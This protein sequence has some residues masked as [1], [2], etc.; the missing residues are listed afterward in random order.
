MRLHTLK[1]RSLGCYQCAHVWKWYDPPN[2]PKQCPKCLS[3]RWDWHQGN[4]KDE[5]IALFGH[6]FVLIHK[7]AMGKRTRIRYTLELTPPQEEDWIQMYDLHYK[8]LMCGEVWIGLMDEEDDMKGN[9]I[10]KQRDLIDCLS[11][12]ASE[13]EQYSEQ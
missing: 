1:T 13:T 2:K 6:K 12:G 10:V 4:E 9:T 11:K 7:I 8:C 3:R 5:S